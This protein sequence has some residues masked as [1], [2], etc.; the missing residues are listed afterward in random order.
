MTYDIVRWADRRDEQRVMDL[1]HLLHKEN[2]LFD[3]D[4]DSVRGMLRKAWNRD[5]GIV[6][7]IGAPDKPLEGAICLCLEQMWY[8]KQWHLGELFNYVHPDHRRSD[9]A[10]AL[11]EFAKA[12][13][14]KLKVPLIIGII[15]NHRTEAKVRLYE[16]RLPKAGAF[17]VYN[18]AT[19]G[20]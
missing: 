7:V 5:G 15:S 4:E 8:S 12:S 18:T 1:C 3:M 9:H 17:F 20:G 16:R 6:G 10:K 19:A 2:G 14:E 11:I 13:A